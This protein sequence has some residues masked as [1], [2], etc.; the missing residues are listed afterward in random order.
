MT[1]ARW[2]TLATATLVLL[3]TA[4][5]G[6][7]LK[8][9]AS[10]QALERAAVRD[11]NDAAAH[12]NLALGYWSQKRWD[13]VGRELG[14]ATAIEYRFAEAHLARAFLVQAR[15]PDLIEAAG[16]SGDT[17]A[18]LTARSE[19]R[20]LYRLAVLLDPFVDHKLAGAIPRK[21]PR[22]SERLG[23]WLENLLFYLGAPPDF[24]DALDDLA[25]GQ[26]EKAFQRLSKLEAE[27]R[28]KDSLPDD[29][30]WYRAVA[31][32]RA[33]HDTAALADLEA[34]LDRAGRAERDSLV[35]DVLRPND[36]RYAIARLNQ[37]LNRIREAETGYRDV[38]VNDLGMYLAHVRLAELHEARRD[39]DAALSERWAALE[40]NGD[41]P[42]LLL[43]MGVTLG[44]AGRLTEADSVLAAAAAAAPRDARV[45]YYRGQ[46]AQAREDSAARA[47]FERFIAMAPARYAAQVADARRRLDA[48][49]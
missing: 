40:L 2:A 3:P 18:L 32:V 44:R 25:E 23:V 43:E 37:R 46:V 6:Q 41:D 1:N 39:W 15:L 29:V 28:G 5:V 35:G 36:Y 14:L 8:L 30:L 49:H 16:R 45:L 34:L 21:R 4:V 47:Y 12:Y 13:D 48:L 27:S 9:P 22:P 31:G 24:F 38:A 26:P 20:R 10:V 42:T 11:S 33:G 7:R 17:T 19:G